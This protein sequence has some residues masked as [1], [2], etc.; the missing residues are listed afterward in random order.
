M[1][2]SDVL[3]LQI[4]PSDVKNSELLPLA[5]KLVLRSNTVFFDRLIRR[6]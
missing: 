6:K 2:L 1:R 5:M 3:L 4:T